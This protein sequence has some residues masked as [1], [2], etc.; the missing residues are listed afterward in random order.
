[1]RHGDQIAE[2]PCGAS[3]ALKFKVR[4]A[5]ASLSTRLLPH[6]SP[7]LLPSARVGCV[8]LGFTATKRGHGLKKREHDP[9]LPAYLLTAHREGYLFAAES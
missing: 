5:L 4:S 2:M 7:P 6:P 3:L 9:E 1:M 8:T